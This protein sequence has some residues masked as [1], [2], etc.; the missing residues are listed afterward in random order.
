TPHKEPAGYYFDLL[1]ARHIERTLKQGMKKASE[2]LAPDNKDPQAAMQAIVETAM[3]LVARK[4]AKQVVDFRDA[5]DLLV[6][7]YVS[8][9]KPPD[10]TGLHL[11]WPKLDAMTGGLGVGDV[12]S[13]IGLTGV[14]KSWMALHAAMHGW[15]K[16][17]L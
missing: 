3:A 12:A 4:N 5:Y 1:E 14:G 7:D 9:W 16:E 13:F 8:K 2:L 6:A 17:A 10:G 11:G 15:K